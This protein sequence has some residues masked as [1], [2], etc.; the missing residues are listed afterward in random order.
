MQD[1]RPPETL[2]IFSDRKLAYRLQLVIATYS[3]IIYLNLK[4][5]EIGTRESRFIRERRNNGTRS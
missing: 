1:H 2:E 5:L 3:T 4:H